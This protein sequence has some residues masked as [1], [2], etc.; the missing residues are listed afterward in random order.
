MAYTKKIR[1]E[2]SKNKGKEWVEMGA[3]RYELDVDWQPAQTMYTYDGPGSVLPYTQRATITIKGYYHSIDSGP[4]TL[5]WATEKIQQMTGDSYPVWLRFGYVDD[6]TY[7][8]A[9]VMLASYEHSINIGTEI[10]EHV[11]TFVTDQLES[12]SEPTVYEPKIAKP[13][14]E[15]IDKAIKALDPKISLITED[16]EVDLTGQVVGWDYAAGPDYTAVQVIPP[17]ATSDPDPELTAK[18]KE[19][20]KNA[21]ELIKKVKAAKESVERASLIEIDQ[22]VEDESKD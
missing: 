19:Y 2:L 18:A 1:V 21:E 13:K 8:Q 11:F 16:G 7:Y 20:A 15:I 6:L 3:Q 17:G 22:E 12:I 9:R 14:K 10:A 5:V 4:Q